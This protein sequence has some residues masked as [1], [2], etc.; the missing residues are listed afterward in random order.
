MPAGRSCSVAGPR[1]EGSLAPYYDRLMKIDLSLMTLTL[2]TIALGAV[3][4]LAS[5]GE[6]VAL[7]AAYE[8]P[9]KKGADGAIAVTFTPLQPKI[10]INENPAPRLKLEDGQTILEDRQPPRKPVRPPAD[11]S[12]AKHLDPKIPV[13]FAVAPRP[14]AP[15]GKHTVTARVTYFFCS[16]LQE[17]CRKGTE[18]VK[19]DVAIP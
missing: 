1:L 3:A 6:F 14:D 18:D 12:N 8:P 10:V 17:W 13:R 16:K 2:A 9:A 5:A 11:P 15:R 19:V 4:G 7:K